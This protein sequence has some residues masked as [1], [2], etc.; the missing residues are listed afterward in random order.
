LNLRTLQPQFRDTPALT[1]PQAREAQ[2][3]PEEINQ[4]TLAELAARLKQELE[5][6]LMNVAARTAQREHERTREWLEKRGLPKAARVA[7]REAYNLLRRY[8]VLRGAPT[9]AQSG[10]EVFSEPQTQATVQ[11]PTAQEL[12]ELA[13]TCLAMLEIHGQPVE[14]T[15]AAL[16]VE[17]GGFLSAADAARV[18]ALAAAMIE[19]E[20]SRHGTPDPA[21]DPSACQGEDDLVRTRP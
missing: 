13:S 15:L 18:R 19:G 7:Q 5:P 11:S 1:A 3:Q 20:Q 14:T 17:A 2:T 8:G 16:G 10:G 21:E 12:E 6:V 9:R 4:A